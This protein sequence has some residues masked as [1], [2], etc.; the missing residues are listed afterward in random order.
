[1]RRPIAPVPLSRGS[2]RAIAVFGL[3]TL[4]AS[5]CAQA[6]AAN[7]G[8]IE[9]RATR[10]KRTKLKRQTPVVPAGVPALTDAAGHTTQ[11]GT[12]PFARDAV[13]ASADQNPDYPGSCG[14]CYEVRCKSGLLLNNE[15]VPIRIVYPDLGGGNISTVG[16]FDGDTAR[17]Y[18]P[19]INPN[20]TDGEG[21]PFPGNM[22]EAQKVVDVRCYDE[23]RSLRV[24]V[25]DSCPC[26][27]VLP[28][29]APGVKPGGEVRRQEW[30]C[31][32]VHHFDLSYWAMEQLAHPVFGAI[33]LNYRPV[34][35]T[36]GT[37][38]PP[39]FI[40]PYIYSAV[41]GI[42]PGWGWFSYD[43][44]LARLENQGPTPIPGGTKSTCV[45][46]APKGGLSFRCRQ[47]QRPGFQP[48]AGRTQLRF[49]IRPDTEDSDPFNTSTPAGEVLWGQAAAEAS[50]KASKGTSRQGV[51]QGQL[52]VH[53][54]GL[55]LFIMQ[56]E[57]KQYCRNELV[58]GNTTLPTGTQGEWYSFVIPLADFGCGGGTGYPEL[59]DIDR[60]DFQNMAIR[61]APPR[62]QAATQPAAL[63]LGPST[64]PPAKRTKAEQA[65]APTQPTKGKGKGKGKGKALNMQ[66]IGEAKYHPLVLCWWPVHEAL[67]AKGKESTVHPRPSSSST[68][69]SRACQV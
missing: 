3:V 45:S 44:Q 21:R 60:V 32:P 23:N 51:Q 46:V 6:P 25:A 31:G 19:S 57:L 18:L 1:M 66:R 62:S 64:S 54:P 48:F 5:C 20:V 47:C 13:A 28:D 30:C 9:G 15:R 34:D 2:K 37:P 35:C 22:G 14:R 43:A 39:N 49:W 12:L 16:Y 53:V 27:Q 41:T 10:K 40:S 69:S 7:G 11:H 33:M 8:W 50:W 17:P 36:T 65:A 38:I 29:G 4:C 63:E 56:E 58:L 67:P 59:A 24:R 61:N 52:V 68:S 55:K 42:G 26:K